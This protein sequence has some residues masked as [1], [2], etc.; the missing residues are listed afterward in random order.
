MGKGCKRLC[1]CP[2]CLSQVVLW[3]SS[4]TDRD[5]MLPDRAGHGA[6]PAEPVA[7]PRG[8][9]CPVPGVTLLPSQGCQLCLHLVHGVWG[10]VAGGEVRR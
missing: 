6:L 10:A 3:E 2:H 1:T 8:W 7:L 4:G 9:D 5:K